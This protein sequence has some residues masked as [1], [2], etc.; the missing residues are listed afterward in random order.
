MREKGID[1]VLMTPF[2]STAFFIYTASK[3][4]LREDL[5]PFHG[6]WHTK[7]IFLQRLEVLKEGGFMASRVKEYV[8][9]KE[10]TQD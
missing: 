10:G 2:L 1:P 4:L 3:R 6:P 5:P 9:A 8:K 7:E